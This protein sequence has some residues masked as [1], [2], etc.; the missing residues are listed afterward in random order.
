MRD[1]V[2]IKTPST[3]FPGSTSKAHLIVLSELICWSTRVI[4]LRSYCSCNNSRVPADRFDISSKRVTDFFQSHSITCFARNFFS[5]CNSKNR[6]SSS[7]ESV[8]MSVFA[9]SMRAAKIVYACFLNMKRY[10]MTLPSDF[11]SLV[12]FI[13][14]SLFTTYSVSCGLVESMWTIWMIPVAS[15]LKLTSTKPSMLGWS[16]TE[17][18]G[19]DWAVTPPS[20]TTLNINKNKPRKTVRS[21]SALYVCTN[22]ICWCRKEA[23]A[24]RLVARCQNY[25]PEPQNSTNK[26]QYS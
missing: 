20:A 10:V 21:N 7:S 12:S 22:D 11:V 25:S 5:P 8:R 4:P 17:T 23:S 24:M 15:I 16:W 2:G 3:T 1:D 14:P 9:L 18:A 26:Q 19:F 6:V 13:F